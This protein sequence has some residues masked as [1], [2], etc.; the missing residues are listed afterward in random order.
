[1][2]VMNEYISARDI[3]YLYH[4]TSQVSKTSTSLKKNV[5]QVTGLLM[6]GPNV[7]PDRISK[8]NRYP[9]NQERDAVLSECFTVLTNGRS[10]ESFGS[11]SFYRASFHAGLY[12]YALTQRRLSTASQV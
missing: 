2:H 12:L 10:A 3:V 9:P 11:L 4:M 5:L 1:M 7:V 6:H 8:P